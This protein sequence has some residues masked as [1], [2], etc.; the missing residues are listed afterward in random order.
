MKTPRRI[1]CMLGVLAAV[2]WVAPSCNGDADDDHSHDHGEGL[3]PNCLD[4]VNACHYKD[5]GTP[6]EVNTCHI[7]GHDGEESECELIRDDCVAACEAAPD[8]SG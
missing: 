8:P 1:A 2:A 7:V 4:I 3:G 5:D 6:G